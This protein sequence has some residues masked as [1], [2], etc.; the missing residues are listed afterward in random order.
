MELGDLLTQK[1]AV[2]RK[3]KALH[4]AH[5]SLKRKK[6][7]MNTRA[8]QQEAQLSKLDQDAF[9]GWQWL[10]EHKKEFEQ[11]VF[12][13][14]LLE[15]ALKRQDYADQ[16]V[17]LLNRRDLLC[18]TA[19]NKAD[20]DKLSDHLLKKEKL[21]VSLRTFKGYRDTFKARVSP[22]ELGFD[23]YAMDFLEGPEPLL[24]QFCAMNGLHKSGVALRELS[25][26]DFDRLTA[27]DDV[28]VWATG[29][30]YYKKIHRRE[31]G[32]AGKSTINKE[33]Y[34][35]DVWKD[36]GRANVD[37]TDI[38]E[39]IRQSKLEGGQLLAER[40]E[41]DDQMEVKQGEKQE[42]QRTKVCHP[43]AVPVAPVGDGDPNAV[44]TITGTTPSRKRPDPEGDGSLAEHSD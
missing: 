17:S 38:D 42:L 1:Q 9:R 3:I 39:K 33:V 35:T 44:N 25:T 19:Q 20:H 18:F 24:A 7:L 23:G 40:K 16:I 29:K 4:E 15:C 26:A 36:Q 14:P 28:N 34:P 5:D 11:E 10:Q 30:M 27:Q 32:D 43:A 37:S 2:S 12:G 13:P 8:G 31:Y 21:S 22:E 6:Q 41:L